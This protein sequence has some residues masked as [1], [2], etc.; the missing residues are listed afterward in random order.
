MQ[1][2]A[3]SRITLEGAQGRGL[4]REDAA[5][6]GCD[7]ADSCSYAHDVQEGPKDYM[8]VYRRTRTGSKMDKASVPKTD[9]LVGTN[10]IQ[11]EQNPGVALVEGRRRWKEWLIVPQDQSNHKYRLLQFEDG[12][13]KPKGSFHTEQE[14][15][16]GYSAL[17]DQA[18]RVRSYRHGAQVTHVAV[19][20]RMASRECLGRSA[21]R[22]LQGWRCFPSCTGSR[23]RGCGTA[24]LP[25]ITR[26]TIGQTFRGF[27]ARATASFV[28]LYSDSCLPSTFP[29]P[30]AK[31]AICN[32][33]S[34]P[35]KGI[36]FAPNLLRALH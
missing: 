31:I 6:G 35:L 29:I 36:P 28:S 22:G 4:T 27:R 12:A 14:G 32:T 25:T 7:Y 18:A 5:Q 17:I 3:V 24:Q 2:D 33:K 1:H 15:I 10:F 26:Q 16:T 11:C 34:E 8:E 23:T 20:A 13:V 30:D 21:T 19:R 9:G